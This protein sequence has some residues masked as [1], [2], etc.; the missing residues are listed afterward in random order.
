MT[1]EQAKQLLPVIQAFAEGKEIQ[2]KDLN[3]TNSRWITIEKSCECNFE[4]AGT[5][6]RIKPTP[7]EF[8]LMIKTFKDNSSEKIVCF[9]LEEAQREVDYELAN[10]VKAEIIHVTEIISS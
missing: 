6:W 10:T 4:R 1:R 2:W 5:S 8:W 7:R 9:S 3:Y